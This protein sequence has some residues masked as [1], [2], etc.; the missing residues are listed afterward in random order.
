MRK[1]IYAA[2]SAL[3]LTTSAATAVHQAPAQHQQLAAGRPPATQSQREDLAWSGRAPAVS[4]DRPYQTA[5]GYGGQRPETDR[6]SPN[7]SANA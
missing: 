2:I 5:Q 1:W 4:T 3:A 6:P 7:G